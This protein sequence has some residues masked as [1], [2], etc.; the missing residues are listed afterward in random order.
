M[1]IIDFIRPTTFIL[2]SII[3]L[4]FSLGSQYVFKIEPCSYCVLIRFFL[5]AFIISEAVYLF[6]G[7]K[8]LNYL[9]FIL[10]IC[11]VAACGYLLKG[12]MVQTIDCTGSIADKF[13]MYTKL[14]LWFPFIFEPKVLCSKGDPYFKLASFV[15]FSSML[16]LFS[17][18]RIWR[19]S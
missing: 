14:D 3:G 9:G 15:Y 1:L 12:L 17:M 6:I 4:I 13:F 11:S 2:F 18:K 19:I 7:K 10:L 16:L 5:I 8:L